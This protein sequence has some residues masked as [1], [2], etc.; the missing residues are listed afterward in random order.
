MDQHKYN[1][2]VDKAFGFLY[3]YEFSRIEG[4]DC[5]CVIESDRVRMQIAYDCHRSFE[6]VVE[7]GMRRQGEASSL[8][9]YSISECLRA[10]NELAAAERFC[11][12]QAA[13]ERLE[14]VLCLISGVVRQSLWSFVT[15]EASVYA[16]AES[17][18]R[19]AWEKYVS[20][21]QRQEYVSLAREAW[22]LAQYDRVVELL[23]GIS[24]SLDNADALRLKLAVERCRKSR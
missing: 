3:E 17:E 23:S 11:L 8:S 6:I 1:Q 7:F 13:P 20:D 24:D 5:L 9:M 16:K 22:H 14:E 15:G 12:I 4:Q 18:R 2:L 10:V 21:K 19:R